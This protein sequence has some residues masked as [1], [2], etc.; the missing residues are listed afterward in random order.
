MLI[1]YGLVFEIR[2]LLSLHVTDEAPWVLI[3]AVHGWQWDPYWIRD[4]RALL[5]AW[6]FVAKPTCWL[7]TVPLPAACTPWTTLVPEALSVITRL[8]WS[9]SPDGRSILRTDDAGGVRAINIGWDSSAILRQ[10]LV[11][12]HQLAGVHRCGRVKTSLHRDDPS[13]A[14]GLQLPRPAATTRFALS[15]HQQLG[16]SGPLALCD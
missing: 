9:V 13:C 4:W 5:A 7:D 15:G 3:A 8:G 14:R 6:R 1:I 11:D 12:A 10:W 2:S 16:R